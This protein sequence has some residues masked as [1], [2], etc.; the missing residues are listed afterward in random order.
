MPSEL[1]SISI[2]PSRSIA[3]TP[4][5]PPSAGSSSHH[6]L[7]HGLAKRASAEAHARA[8][9]VRHRGA[10]EHLAVPGRRHRAAAVVGVGACADQRRIADASEALAGHPAGRG[11]RGEPARRIQ[12]DRADGAHVRDGERREAAVAAANALELPPAGGGVEIIARRRIR[13]RGMPRTPPRPLRSGT[14]IR[15]APSRRA[16]ARSGF[17]MRVRPHTAPASRVAPFMI[18]ASSSLRPSSVNTAPRP[19]L[20]SASSS[21]ATTA[22]RHRVQARA[23]AAE[24]R[25]PAA[26]A[27]ARPARY[28]ASRSALISARGRVPAPP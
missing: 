1:N 2:R 20:N 24:H 10:D 8:D 4:P 9:V 14:R 18:E 27:A 17:L 5:S 23:P 28:S 12:R 15:S 7:M 13:S 25:K 11:C 19:A 21:S 6:H 3:M 16:R 22:L 26:S